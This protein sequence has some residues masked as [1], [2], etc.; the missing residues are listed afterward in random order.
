MDSYE[1][2]TG[3]L[4][5]IFGRYGG[6]TENRRLWFAVGVLFI[7]FVF[8]TVLSK[9]LNM[10]IPSTWK[11]LLVGGI[12]IPFIAV[13]SGN[14]KR[15]MV[16]IILLSMPLRIDITL[17]QRDHVG[18]PEGFIVGI[19]DIC[20][21]LLMLIWLVELY[22]ERERRTSPPLL[23][24]SLPVLGLIVM[25]LASMIKAYDPIL[26]LFQLALIIKMYLFM[27]YMAYYIAHTR[28]VRFVII[29]LLF[30]L[31]LESSIAILQGIFKSSFN[32]PA[33][34]TR[35]DNYEVMLGE[36]AIYRVGGTVGG[37][38]PLS[39]Y[40][41]Y[42][43]PIPLVLLFI[44]TKSRFKLIFAII[45]FLALIAQFMTY[46]RAG[47]IGLVV[48]LVMIILL[49]M[50][51]LTVWK[52]IIINI[53]FIFILSFLVFQILFT[54]NEIKNRFIEDDR[55]S[56]YVRIPLMKVAVSIIA[57]NPI[58]GIGLNNYTEVDQE[59]DPTPEKISILWPAPV[60]NIY[61]KIGAEMGIPGLICF[62]WFIGIIYS[63]GYRLIRFDDNAMNQ[64]AI[65]MCVGI[66][67]FLI[68]GMVDTGSLGDHRF[69]PIFILG[70]ILIGLNHIMKQNISD[71]MKPGG[72]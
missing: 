32:I 70:G 23:S 42:F 36:K 45:F 52:K 38:N 14:V 15:F 30:G 64:I 62:I 8:G 7:G 26:S 65:G 39:A 58:L 55:G 44:K 16:A 40:L 12:S 5:R 59:Y 1:Y 28:D 56:A 71:Q 17:A 68:H 49:N 19:Q 53:V 20:L 69:F 41:N 54:D 67:T 47:W 51:R 4:I 63:Y 6:L 33:F 24:I 72:S 37:A 29:C 57:S 3:H 21:L 46:S 18:G 31:F 66:T 13:I 50:R 34:G 10:P 22:Q 48:G 27:I 60:H 35:A 43:I 9:M 11:F 25:G 61:L 2:K